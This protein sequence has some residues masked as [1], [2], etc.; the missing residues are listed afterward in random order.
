M[1]TQMTPGEKWCV[2]RMV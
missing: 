2:H 1:F